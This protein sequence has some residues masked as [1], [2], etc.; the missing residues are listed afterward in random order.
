MIP[1]IL[2]LLTKGGEGGG[3]TS[4]KAISDTYLLYPFAMDLTLPLTAVRVRLMVVAPR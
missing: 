4:N 3:T 2:I 1:L